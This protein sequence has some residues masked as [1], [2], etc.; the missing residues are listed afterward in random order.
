MLRVGTTEERIAAV[1]H[2]VVEDTDVTIERLEAEGFSELVLRAVEALTKREGENY[3]AFIE[4]AAANP[5]A[6]VVKR[7]DLAENSD[8]SRIPIPTEK[9][10]Q[11]VEKYRRAIAQLEALSNA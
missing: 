9:D 6:R 10:R 2:D 7:A 4:R 8:L 3:E 1:L 11:R 5:V